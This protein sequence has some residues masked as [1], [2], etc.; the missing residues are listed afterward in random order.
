MYPQVAGGINRFC[1]VT[2]TGAGVD[3]KETDN[4]YVKASFA[5]SA[6]SGPFGGISFNMEDVKNGNYVMMRWDIYF[7]SF[8]TLFLRR[9]SMLTTKKT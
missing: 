8:F 3:V 7:I 9:E 1:V 4:F 5:T 2:L 6:P